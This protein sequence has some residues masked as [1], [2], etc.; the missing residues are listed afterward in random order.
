MHPESPL[1]NPIF[2]NYYSKK[3][4]L[5]DRLINE[6]LFFSFHYT[7]HLQSHLINTFRFIMSSSTPSE[8]CISTIVIIC[9]FPTV[10]R[11][12]GICFLRILC[13]KVNSDFLTVTY[14]K[15]M[16]VDNFGFTGFSFCQIRHMSLGSPIAPTRLWAMTYIHTFSLRMTYVH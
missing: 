16:F 13:P 6:I 4:D 12:S 10:F 14:H 11:P 15:L 2:Q 1:I 8:V 3:I 5:L 9:H 7:N